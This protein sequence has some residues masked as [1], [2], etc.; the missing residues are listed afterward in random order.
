MFT[1]LVNFIFGNFIAENGFLI[2]EKDNVFTIIIDDFDIL[3]SYDEREDEVC[4]HN[5]EPSI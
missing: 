3:V 4:S 2:S 5:P 1:A